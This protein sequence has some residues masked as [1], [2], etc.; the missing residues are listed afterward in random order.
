MPDTKLFKTLAELKHEFNNKDHDIDK[1]LDWSKNMKSEKAKNEGYF[2]LTNPKIRFIIV[3]MGNMGSG[4]SDAIQN[5]KEFCSLINST[6]WNRPW[7]TFDRDKI[8]Q[9]TPKYR[10]VV[11]KFFKDNPIPVVDLKEDKSASNAQPDE[12]PPSGESEKKTDGPSPDVSEKKVGDT[13]EKKED[14]VKEDDVKEDDKKVVDTGDDIIKRGE[15]RI[16]YLEALQDGG[17][18]APDSIDSVDEELQYIEDIFHDSGGTSKVT[19]LEN[20]YSCLRFGYNSLGDEEKKSA[21]VEAMR[22][23]FKSNQ[24]QTKILQVL[25]GKRQGDEE[26]IK[27]AL[28]LNSKKCMENEETPVAVED[29]EQQDE[30]KKE[31]ENEE[32]EQNKTPPKPHTRKTIGENLPIEVKTYINISKAITEG[33]NIIYESTGRSFSK[34]KEIF[35]NIAKQCMLDP[36][37]DQEFYY[38]AIGLVNIIDPVANKARLI[39][40]FIEEGRKFVESDTNLPP[41]GTRIDLQKIIEDQEQIKENI[42]TIINDCTCPGSDQTI[43]QRTGEC[44]NIGLDYIMIYDQK[45]CNLR[46]QTPGTASVIVPISKRSNYIIKIGKDKP[47]KFTKRN[48][49]LVNCLFGPGHNVCGGETEACE[50]SCVNEETKERG[51]AAVENEFSKTVELKLKAKRMS[52]RQQE[53]RQK[54]SLCGGNRRTRKNIKT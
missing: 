46:A 12:P 50:D 36:A 49:K 47:I 42:T 19:P 29:G 26:A 13:G 34:I 25:N 32:E 7:K 27:N 2:Q 6:S 9:N 15:L 31:V 10:E 48:Q 20:M 28:G 52:R 21:T 51:A 40:R 24:V 14:V 54:K 23:G 3:A 17:C 22:Y 4:K 5:S 43:A 53:L 33:K 44:T 38:I 8:I 39:K 41:L 35:R 11:S 37:K 1:C 18:A 45:Y 16:A 30:G